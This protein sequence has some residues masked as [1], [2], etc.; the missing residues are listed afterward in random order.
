MIAPDRSAAGLPREG[1]A[2]SKG[3]DEMRRGPAHDGR[4]HRQRIESLPSTIEVLETRAPLADGITAAAAPPLHAVVGVPLKNALFATYTVTDPAGAPGTQ[5]RALINF[6]DH[7]TDGPV[8]PVEKGSEFE[9]VDTHTYAAPGNYTVT[10]MI[11]VPG[12]GLPNDNTVTTQVSVTTSTPTPT[13]TSPQPPPTPQIWATGLRLK[14]KVNRTFHGDVVNFKEAGTH[15]N[16]FQALINWGDDSPPATG[17]IR[18]LGKRGFAVIG[19]HR[20]ATPGFFHVFVRI[21]GPAG[22]EIVPESLIRVFLA[23]PAR[24]KPK[25]TV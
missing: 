7:Q 15:A 5:W 23:G 10:I 14:A 18:G 17:R 24:S 2:N 6:G 12:S 1:R 25:K 13:P 11:A 16:D 3:V 21:D 4:R 19:S 9:F 22:Q 20:Y 8:F